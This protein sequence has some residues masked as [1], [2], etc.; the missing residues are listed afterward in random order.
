MSDQS[1][2]TARAVEAMLGG[3]A[4]KLPIADL[5]TPVL[6]VERDKLE[7]NIKRMQE[8][9]AKA[10]IAYR[11]HAKAHKSSTIAALQIA[12]GAVGQCC[13]KLG[14]A[15][16]MA[17]CGVN[18]ILI[19]S[20]VVG[21]GKLMRLIEL[22]NA[23]R[24]AVVADDAG[25]IQDLA[26]VAQTAGTRLDV[27]VEVDVG[28]GRCG[29]RP[30]PEAAVLAQQIADSRWLRFRGLQGYQGAIQMVATL[31]ERRAKVKDALDRLLETAEHVRKRGLAIEALTGGGTGSSVIDCALHG[32]TE[33]QPGSYI[34]MD[35]KY[36]A[37]EWDGA[38]RPPFENAL[39]VLG[40]VISRPGK[41]RAIVDVGMK[42]ASSDGGPILPI[43]LP[44]ASFA[45][46]GDE[47]GQLSFAGSPCPLE[48]GDKVWFVPS[49]C[50]T[51]VNLYDRYVAVR[52]GLV[53]EVWDIEA[54]GR[55][56]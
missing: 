53:E 16:V 11:P 51:T 9:A 13:A 21:R 46:A 42:A 23:A 40:T 25:N 30:G 32:L 1:D 38:P 29:V 37:I 31:A 36:A 6:L 7:R 34:F 26:R 41:D 54:R 24:I 27:L 48:I 47:H 10:G 15:E 45:F 44:G 8:V 49:H 17:H 22:A 4:A 35:S 14:E 33:L 18:D 43:D 2:A 5:D 55:V 3:S 20:E 28:Q 12:A 50:D 39:F 56:Q 19:T 52:A